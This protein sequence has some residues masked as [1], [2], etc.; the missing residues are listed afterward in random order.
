MVF[1]SRGMIHAFTTPRRSMDIMGQEV[2]GYL[3]RDPSVITRYLKEGN[4]LGSEVEKV[5]AKLRENT[6]E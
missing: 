5:H 2:A 4:R 1:E 6:G 3:W